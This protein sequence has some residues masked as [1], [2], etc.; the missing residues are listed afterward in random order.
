MPR[1][2]GFNRD[3]GVFHVTHRCHNRAF[4]LKFARDRDAYRATL[5]EQVRESN[6]FVLDYCLTSNHVHLL[7]DAQEER[8][9]IGKLMQ[10]VEGQFARACN[11]HKERENAYWG[12]NYHAT[13]VQD[14]EYLWRCLCYIEL[15]L[16]RC[17]VVAHPK[18]WPW[19]GYHEIMGTRR[20]YRL[21]DLERLCW[22]LRASSLEE[23]RANLAANL[24]EAI[25]R[26]QVKRQEHWTECLAVGS[27]EFVEAAQPRAVSRLETEIVEAEQAL[28]VL[29]EAPAPYGQK[30]R[31]KIACK[32]R[33]RAIFLHIVL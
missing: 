24:A 22:R 20:R 13:L 19:L 33:K 31:P 2:N 18:D 21:I 25:A 9:E 3:G 10:A 26:Q 17:G 29:K 27:R 30:T 23:V 14:G 11:R 12:D 7:L 15:N 28:W 32:A 6:L 16:V 4:L 1:A 5:R 8:S